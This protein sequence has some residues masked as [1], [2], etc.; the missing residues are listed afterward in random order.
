MKTTDVL[1]IGGGAVGVCA[2][3]F[4]N[5]SGYKVILVEQAGIGSGASHGN[6]GLVVPSHSV[7]L[8]NP[9][10]I[11]HGLGW[12]FKPESPFYIKPRLDIPLMKWLWEFWRASGEGSV[13]KAIPLIRD[14]S[15]LSLSLFNDLDQLLDFNFQKQGLVSLCR[16]SKG[17]EENYQEALLLSS[18][19]L[20]IDKQTPSSFA[21]LLG[22]LEV[23]ALGGLFFKQ[24]GHLTPSKFVRRLADHLRSTDVTFL[25]DTQVS[26]FTTSNGCITSTETSAGPIKAGT[27]VVTAGCWS[28]FLTKQLDVKLLIQPA[29]GYSI[30]LKRPSR[31]PEIPLMLFESRVAVTPMGDF[32]R[33]GGTLEL[34]GMDFKINPRRIAAILK[35]IPNYLP[36]LDIGTNDILETWCGL[37]PC[38]PDGLPFLGKVSNVSNLVIAAGH[39]MIGI[40]LA[41][42]TGKLVS[43]IVGAEKTDVDISQFAVNRF[44][45]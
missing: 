25:T 21:P 27:V 7:P 24:D 3:Y 42:A 31:W 37:R 32:L 29:K 13:H 19:G 22:D 41:P 36:S 20:K 44:G 18:Y 1:I 4:L 9:E 2:A 6:L 11:S 34:S 26:G 16:T 45:A 40:S 5:K 15:L 8:S 14:M 28:S 43:Q 23:K 35:A 39:A 10:A 30:T 12:M 38:T 17:L 33:I